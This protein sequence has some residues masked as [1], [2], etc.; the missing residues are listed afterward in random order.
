[1]KKQYTLISALALVLGICSCTHEEFGQDHY[2][3]SGD[4]VRLILTAERGESVSSPATRIYVGETSGGQNGTS[5]SV[6]YHWNTSDKIGVLPLNLG[7]TAAPNYESPL[8]EIMGD[9]NYAQFETYFTAEG[10]D[11]T[12]NYA[13]S[14]IIRITRRCFKV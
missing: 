1:M 7:T 4:K 14:Y 6:R 13:F 11:A 3:E 12:T 2:I 9:K 10:F 8:T 5:G